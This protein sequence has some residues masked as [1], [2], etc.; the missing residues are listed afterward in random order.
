MYLDGFLS[1]KDRFQPIEKGNPYLQSN[2][3]EYIRVIITERFIAKT[4]MKLRR[5]WWVHTIFCYYM[6]TQYNLGD[7]FVVIPKWCYLIYNLGDLW[8]QLW[9]NMELHSH[10]P[11]L[12]T[13]LEID[14]NFP[15]NFSRS[16]DFEAWINY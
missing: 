15:P 7:L 5:R 10:T 4:F 9:M 2:Q 1:T 3:M 13:M 6:P 14:G 16:H 11:I 12:T 8:G